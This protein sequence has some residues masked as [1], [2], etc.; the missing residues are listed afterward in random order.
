MKFS[1]KLFTNLKNRQNGAKIKM[2]ST[3]IDAKIQTL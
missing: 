1:E 3:K 2:N